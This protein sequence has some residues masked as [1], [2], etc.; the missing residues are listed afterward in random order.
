MDEQERNR[1]L[2]A[3]IKA[4]QSPLDEDMLRIMRGMAAANLDIPGPRVIQLI[5]A[6]WALLQ[7]SR[8]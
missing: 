1:R 4:G 5:D 2:V 7:Q 8:I 6:Y 3:A